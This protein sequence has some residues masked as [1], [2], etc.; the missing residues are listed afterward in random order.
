M[1]ST[2]GGG[3]RRRIPM[4]DT[5][6]MLFLLSPQLL[7]DH[8][9]YSD[10]VRIGTRVSIFLT[11]AFN[12]LPGIREGSAFFLR[13]PSGKE[14]TSTS[15]G[16]PRTTTSSV[17]KKFMGRMSFSRLF[18]YLLHDSDY[19]ARLFR[20]V[21]TQVDQLYASIRTSCLMMRL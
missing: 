20:I 17:F 10:F 2:G 9:K 5:R 18:R 6:K 3:L 11:A 8:L 15:N 13:N 12:V 21:R 19:M 14:N 1:P 16:L 7:F 4:M